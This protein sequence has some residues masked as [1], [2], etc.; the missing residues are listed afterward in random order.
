MT[1]STAV[2]APAHGHGQRQNSGLARSRLSRPSGGS[3]T[4]EIDRSGNVDRPPPP[5]SR[6]SSQ[7]RT[8]ARQLVQPDWTVEPFLEAR[9]TITGARSSFAV[10]HPLKGNKEIEAAASTRSSSSSA[11]RD[12]SRVIPVI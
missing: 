11:R 8:N 1:S 4:Q 3:P 6:A 10:V 9:F 5:C 12:A 7:H 2:P